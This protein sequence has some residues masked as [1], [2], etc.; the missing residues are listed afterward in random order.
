MITGSITG[1]KCKISPND[2]IPLADYIVTGTRPAHPF[3]V[4]CDGKHLTD[5]VYN[6]GTSLLQ[7]GPRSVAI[8]IIET[9]FA[10]GVVGLPSHLVRTYES[11]KSFLLAE[12]PTG[13]AV[14]LRNILE[15]FV[16][17]NFVVDCFHGTALNLKSTQDAKF[18]D[19]LLKVVDKKLSISFILETMGDNLVY[20]GT[21]YKRRTILRQ[22]KGRNVPANA[23]KDQFFN[24]IQT[25][26]TTNRTIDTVV[27]WELYSAFLDL[28]ESVHGRHT[29]AIGRLDDILGYLLNAI[30]DYRVTNGNAWKVIP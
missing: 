5:I 18:Y 9:T 19:D 3:L 29:P 13:A 1:L 2:R 27:S 15:Y 4:V 21:Y 8:D 30:G 6:S 23:E 12:I 28:S 14:L 20:R 10:N 16:V 25:N 26:R 22:G 11:A 24:F 7:E 17:Q